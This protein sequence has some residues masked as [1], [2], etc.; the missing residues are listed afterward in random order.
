MA[1]ARL[2]PATASRATPPSLAREFAKGV[3]RHIRLVLLMSLLNSFSRNISTQKSIEVWGVCGTSPRG[4]Q[5]GG[6]SFSA[7][8]GRGPKQ[9]K[10]GELESGSRQELR[11]ALQT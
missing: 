7:F 9:E 4:S 3:S 1:M 5:P 6:G 2:A 10:A 8:R 11:A